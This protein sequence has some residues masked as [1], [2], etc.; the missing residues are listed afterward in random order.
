MCKKNKCLCFN[1]IRW[2]MVKK[3]RL[4]MKNS[5]TDTTYIDLGL[6]IDTDLL[7]IKCILV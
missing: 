2:F 5:H 3:M 6:E 7:N 1:E 4:E